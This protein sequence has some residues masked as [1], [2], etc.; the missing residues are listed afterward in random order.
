MPT[1][2]ATA[3]L[4]DIL[5]RAEEE[6]EAS[7]RWRFLRRAP[8]GA[9]IRRLLAASTRRILNRLR[10]DQGKTATATQEKRRAERVALRRR[11]PGKMARPGRARDSSM[12]DLSLLSVVVDF[13]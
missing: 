11:A 1:L 7:Q 4:H 6:D 2:F 5:R 8:F 12:P 10:N 13:R 3:A 9:V